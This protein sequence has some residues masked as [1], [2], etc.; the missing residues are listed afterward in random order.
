MKV[1]SLLH[2]LLCVAILGAFGTN[3]VSAKET[4]LNF[5]KAGKPAAAS[6]NDIAAAYGE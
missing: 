2:A 4:E 5:L 6:S 1:K 3:L